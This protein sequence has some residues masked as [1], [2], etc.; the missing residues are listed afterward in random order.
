MMAVFLLIDLFLKN[1]NGKK[2][3]IGRKYKMVQSKK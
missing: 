3:L 2:F 1:G